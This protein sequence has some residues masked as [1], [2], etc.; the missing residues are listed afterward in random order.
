[1]ELAIDEDQLHYPVYYAI[2]RDGKA[3]REMPADPSAPADLT[4]IFEAIIADIPAPQAA[5]GP[6]QLMV[7]SLQYDSSSANTRLAGLHVAVLQNH[8][9]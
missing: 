9:Q 7:T 4:P 8:C 2:G 3:W 6:F 1:M 5:D